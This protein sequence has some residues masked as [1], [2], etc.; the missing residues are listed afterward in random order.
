MSI[1]LKTVAL[2]LGLF[3]LYLL[4]DLALVILVSIV[5]ASAVEPPV[6]WLGRFRLPRAVA[7]LVVYLLTFGIF[8]GLLPFFVF[9]LISD[10]SALSGTLSTTIG[11]IP[12]FL[13]SAGP[14]AGFELGGVS[15]SQ[16]FQSF[17][18]NI[19]DLPKSFV[20]TASFIFGGFF[21]FILIVVISFYLAVQPNGLAN[22]LRL[23]TPWRQ[24]SYV[25]GLWERSRQ[26]IG[27]WMQGQLLLG[28]LIGVLVYLGL[29]LFKVP[30]A[31]ALA[32]L[33]ASFELIPYFGPVLASVPA[34][35]LGFSHS[36]SLGFLV[37]GFYV[38]IQQ[39][40]NHLIY[41][42]VVTKMVGVPPLVVILSL[43][44]GANLAGFMGII[45]AV[46][47]ATVLMELAADFEKR[48]YLGRQ[49]NHG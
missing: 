47:L 48:K 30:Y 9:P 1:V 16:V 39:F 10:L 49:A 5:I 41:P 7:V 46:P 26:K 27:Y 19:V 12:D 11:T 25:L 23:I 40:E 38:I 36:V 3:V 29:T 33:A 22:F 4:R 15:L 37:I 24:E 21:S 43:L 8:V 14:W 6:R 34:A 28:V 42:L 17:Q 45:L 44:V 35:L 18:T 13:S 2:L 20:Q 31:L 32:L